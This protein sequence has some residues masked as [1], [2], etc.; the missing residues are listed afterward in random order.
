MAKKKQKRSRSANVRSANVRSTT[1]K[2]RGV[3]ADGSIMIMADKKKL[4]A[5]MKKCLAESGKVTFHLQDVSVT[6]LGK[7]VN[8]E[9]IVN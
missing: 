3:V 4:E 9:N 1:V 6:K 7:L 2:A 8:L 5:A